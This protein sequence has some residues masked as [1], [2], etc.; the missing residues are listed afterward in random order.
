MAA[1]AAENLQ[2]QIHAD[3]E[4]QARIAENEGIRAQ[5][6]AASAAWQREMA[7]QADAMNVVVLGLEEQLRDSGERV[8]EVEAELEEAHA[9]G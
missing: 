4:I 9:H 6:V 3:K 1:L 5:A 2:I 7:S 8:E